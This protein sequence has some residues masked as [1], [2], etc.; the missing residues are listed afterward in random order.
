MESSAVEYKKK[1]RLSFLLCK[2]NGN[3]KWE[4]FQTRPQHAETKAFTS[5]EKLSNRMLNK[6]S[7]M[8]IEKK[9][10]THGLQKYKS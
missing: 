3:T 6:N 9:G 1:L 2:T 5:L 10:G 4:Y 8:K 7:F